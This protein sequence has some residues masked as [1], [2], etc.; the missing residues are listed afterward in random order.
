MEP[1][2]ATPPAPVA[3]DAHQHF[4]PVGVRPRDPRTAVLERAFTPA[5]LERELLGGEVGR[6][7]LVQCAAGP[8]ENDRLVAYA[9]DFAPAGA[10]VLW[11]P[12]ADPDAARRELGRVSALSGLVRG[13]RAGVPRDTRAD[14]ALLRTMEAAERA[15]L[16]WELVVTSGSHVALVEE[17]AAARPDL[18][19]V[20][21]HLA[22]PPLAAGARDVWEGWIDRLA[23]L[24]S[25]AVKVSVG[26][27]VLV[28][29]EWEP[30]RLAPYVGRALDAFGAHR[31]ML[32]GN[33]PV[34]RLAADHAT[35][36]RALRAAVA[37]NGASETESALVAGGSARRWYRIGEDGN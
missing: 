34:V 20:V 3:V 33:W 21:D 13:F 31:S 30:D 37:A 18:P 11:L 9:R 4:W 25:V 32:A 29:W 19:I 24:P 26:G 28:G 27:D 35:A 1:V 12:L 16:V 6:T 10:L 7:V 36:W 2:S 23:A 5:D 17:V 8:E 22:T 15:G 14:P